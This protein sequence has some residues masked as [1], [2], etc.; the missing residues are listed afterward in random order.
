MPIF[1]LKKERCLPLFIEVDIFVCMNFIF[2]VAW[3][4]Q[5]D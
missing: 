2:L 3:L 4:F 5:H 1:S